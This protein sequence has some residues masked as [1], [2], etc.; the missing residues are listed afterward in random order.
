MNKSFQHKSFQSAGSSP[1][2]DSEIQAPSPLWL[3]SLTR[4]FQGC[5]RKGKSVEDQVWEW[6]GEGKTG[7]EAV[8]TTF[9]TFPYWSKFCRRPHPNARRRKCSLA[10]G[11]KEEET[12]VNSQPGSATPIK[13]CK[14][15]FATP[16]TPFFYF[17]NLCSGI[18][19][20]WMVWKCILLLVRGLEV[21]ETRTLKGI[22]NNCSSV[23]A[24]KYKQNSGLRKQLLILGK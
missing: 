7:W 22:N 11:Q 14:Q 18:E 6:S 8:Y 17:L 24:R 12:G 9:P 10:V 15:T 3:P 19:I 16:L 20:G 1:G 23:V 5:C 13:A 21:F 4:G 2:G